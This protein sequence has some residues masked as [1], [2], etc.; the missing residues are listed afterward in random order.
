MLHLPERTLSFITTG[1]TIDKQYNEGK[2]VENFTFGPE[3]E[4]WKILARMHSNIRE[5]L[6]QLPP[7][8]SL[9]MSREDHAKIADACADADTE[10]VVVLHGTDRMIKT[11]EYIAK[12]HLKK[13][14]VLTGASQPASMRDSDADAN[15]GG[16]MALAQIAPHGVYI[17]MHGMPYL[18]DECRKTKAGTFERIIRMHS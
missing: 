17:F 3:S 10:A 4:L 14:I 9:H 5:G 18:W 8:D 15:V 7:L 16:A 1:G 6:T 11:A 13:T 12:R 2:S